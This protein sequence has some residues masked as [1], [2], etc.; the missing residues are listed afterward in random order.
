MIQDSTFLEKAAAEAKSEQNKE[1]Q[2]NAAAAQKSRDEETLTSDAGRDR[3][4]L[5]AQIGR[6]MQRK[7]IVRRLQKLRSSLYYEQSKALASRGGLY[8]KGT[9]LVGME[10]G[11]SPEFSVMEPTEQG[12]GRVSMRGWRSILAALIRIRYI[13]IE[14]AEREFAITRGHASERWW[15]LVN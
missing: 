13:T 1:F 5:E 12:H 2:R 7:E 10:H 9:F 15:T 8:V 14:D 4:N 6:P 11:I 3:T